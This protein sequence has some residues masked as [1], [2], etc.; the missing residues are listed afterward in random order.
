MQ[1]KTET[2]IEPRSTINFKEFPTNP[3]LFNDELKPYVSEIIK[4]HGLEE[5]K[6]VVLTNELTIIWGSGLL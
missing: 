5:W 3:A 6:A 2:T 4:K 1:Q